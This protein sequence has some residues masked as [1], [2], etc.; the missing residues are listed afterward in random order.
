[1]A[2]KGCV[3]KNHGKM[4]F[5]G[6]KLVK[7]SRCG[8]KKS[9]ATKKGS[10]PCYAVTHKDAVKK[11][12]VAHERAVKAAAT[13]AAKAAREEALTNQYNGLGR[14]TRRRRRHSR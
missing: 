11:L 5:C 8:G 13:K 4:C 12:K 3:K 6:G 10:G 2:K 7:L 9:A 1:M 14:V